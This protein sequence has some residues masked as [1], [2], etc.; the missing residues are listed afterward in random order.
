MVGG[1]AIGAACSACNGGATV[2][3]WLEPLLVLLVGA[4]DLAINVG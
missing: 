4:V 3:P 2:V 1:G